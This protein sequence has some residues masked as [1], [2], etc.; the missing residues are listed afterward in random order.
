M[1]LLEEIDIYGQK[2]SFLIF[3]HYHFHSIISITLTILV[4][5]ISIFLLYFL[6]EDFFFRKNPKTL[7]STAI[8]DSGFMINLTQTTYFSAWR[9]EDAFGNEINY[10]NIIYPLLMY[11]NSTSQE[12]E[13]ISNEKCDINNIPK[14]IL[15]LDIINYNCFTWDNRYFGGDWDQDF[16]YYFSFGL[17][18]CEGGNAFGAGN[19]CTQKKKILD[20]LNHKDLVYLSVFLPYLNFVPENKVQPYQILYHQ[21]YFL[22]TPQLQKIDKVKIHQTIVNDDKNYFVTRKNNETVWNTSP[23]ETTY[24][25]FDFSQYGYENYSSS[26]YTMNF[27]MDKTYTYYKRFYVKFPEILAIASAF[28]K[29]CYLLLTIL[30]S[31]C[32]KILIYDK[33]GE[34]YFH[35][36]KEQIKNLGNLSIKPSNK[37]LNNSSTFVDKLSKVETQKI[38]SIINYNPK[39]LLKK[40]RANINNLSFYP[41]SFPLYKSSFS[42][43]VILFYKCFGFKTNEK[44]NNSF[45]LLVKILTKKLDIVYYLKKIREFSIVKKC[46]YTPT[47]LKLLKY[48]KK[49]DIN[50][51]DHCQRTNSDFKE[52]NN[53]LYKNRHN[54]D[55][56]DQEIMNNLN[57]FSSH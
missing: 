12:Y 48:L 44:Q 38:N 32:N 45:H 37:H 43:W 7:E 26:L 41:K 34:H 17:Y 10:K 9:L 27:Y 16:L 19:K 14:S 55:S 52:I 23:I 40:P 13:T 2:F 6:G 4:S 39:V 31:Y 49:K 57:F 8:R 11:Y 56:I 42:M 33:L 20:F 15:N 1:R 25:F 21:Y 54:H 29:I 3:N 50:I 35:F 30:A 46:I 28:I 36:P 5:I 22:L 47:Q 18:F 53:Y 51:S 24:Y